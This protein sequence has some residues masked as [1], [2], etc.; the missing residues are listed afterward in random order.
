MNTSLR[1]LPEYAQLDLFYAD[2]SDVAIR[3]LQDVMERPFFSLDTKPRF[4]PLRYTSKT[5][6]IV[7]SGG[8]PY[9]VATIFDHDILMWIVGQ[10]VEARDKG[11][12][13]S[14]QLYFTPYDC[15]RG[16][17]RPTD[18]RRYKLLA[19]A[20][21]RLANTYVKTDI[22]KDDQIPLSRVERHR[23]RAGFHWLESFAIQSV[24]RNG[25]DVP[26]GIT[27]VI[28]NWLY[29]GAL[30][31]GRILTIDERY[32]LM[33]SGLDRML[34]LI[35]RKHVGRQDEQRFTMRQL[36]KKT[37]SE[38][39]FK[40][41]AIRIR[42]RVSRDEKEKVLPEYA[43]TKYHGQHDDEVVVF[44]NRSRLDSEDPRYESPRLDK[45]IQRLRIG[46]LP[47]DADEARQKLYA[48]RGI[49]LSKNAE[50][51]IEEHGVDN[52]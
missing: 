25:K 18:G 31:H 27:A 48:R 43:M 17:Y 13:T 30:N 33:R 29:R 36:Y 4:K 41:F 39:P 22:R 14:P 51:V 28:P 44:W 34:Y 45:R 40:D 6:E 2:F 47:D 42:K 3:A 9:G 35:A 32:F 16:I 37:G 1:K 52:S 46:L 8:E 49:D 5:A 23:L 38:I 7:I 21:D 20:L 12:P 26:K 10:I 50:K 19:D 15:L 11:E 24:E